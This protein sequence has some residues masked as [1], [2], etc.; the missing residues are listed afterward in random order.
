MVKRIVLLFAFASAFLLFG[1]GN[2]IDKQAKSNPNEKTGMD[3]IKML[4]DIINNSDPSSMSNMFYD[5]VSS[6]LENNEVIYTSK[7]NNTYIKIDNIRKNRGWQKRALMNRLELQKSQNKPFVDFLKILVN[8]D[9]RIKYVYEGIADIDTCQVIVSTDDLKH[10]LDAD[11]QL[12]IDHLKTEIK[13][14]QIHLPLQ[15]DELTIWRDYSIV[16]NNVIY[17]YEIDE[18]V[19]SMDYLIENRDLLQSNIAEQLLG[20]DNADDSFMHQAKALGLGMSYVYFGSITNKRM[21]IVFK[22]EELL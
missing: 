22:N 6:K 19:A 13:S 16:G 5:L 4:M 7:P 14:V 3:T 8:N 20:N 9:I 17:L 2:P 12:T 10:V 21:E 18:S 1:C 15:L 11:G